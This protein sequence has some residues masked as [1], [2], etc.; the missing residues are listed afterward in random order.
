VP[1][2]SQ[3]KLC[4][5]KV[6]NHSNIRCW[7]IAFLLGKFRAAKRPDQDAHDAVFGVLSILSWTAGLSQEILQNR[8]ILTTLEVPCGENAL[9]R[10]HT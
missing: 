6:L 2:I 4:Q 9:R 3:V 7:V 10:L 8:Y 1:P 5:I